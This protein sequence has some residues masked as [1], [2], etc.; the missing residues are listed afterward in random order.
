MK[1]SLNLFFVALVLLA[2]GGRLV[3]Q[4]PTT[5]TG[6]LQES[7]LVPVVIN[8]KQVGNAALAKGAVVS[9]LREEGERLLVRNAMGSAWIAKTQIALSVAPAAAAPIPSAVSTSSAVPAAERKL[10]ILIAGDGNTYERMAVRDELRKAG[11]QVDEKFLKATD[12][13]MVETNAVTETD[14]STYDVFFV[15][16]LHDPRSYSPELFAKLLKTRNKLVI[17]G[18]THDPIPEIRKYGMTVNFNN[19]Y[20]SAKTISKNHTVRGVKLDGDVNVVESEDGGFAGCDII[21][22]IVELTTIDLRRSEVA[23]PAYA[24]QTQRTLLPEIL[25]F[26]KRL[27]ARLH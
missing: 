20:S 26:M 8:G 3:A 7:V 6:I 18:R 13:H 25:K 19:P 11:Y 12:P 2:L 24:V 15:D 27:E 14:L 9:V 23:Q 16:N 10:K 5:R 22:Y 17:V 21:T 1:T 4:Q